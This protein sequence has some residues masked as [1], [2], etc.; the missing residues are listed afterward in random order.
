ML[1]Q[2]VVSVSLQRWEL[3]AG[4]KGAADCCLPR[5]I[6]R[7]RR[8]A[9]KQNRSHRKDHKYHLK[10]AIKAWIHH[11]ANEI[12][13]FVYLLFIAQVSIFL[14]GNA[15]KLYIFQVL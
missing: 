10:G 4:K 7:G 3:R 15:A 8:H 5:T 12:Y 14:K 13:L 11:E 2:H 1:R 9:E 6:V